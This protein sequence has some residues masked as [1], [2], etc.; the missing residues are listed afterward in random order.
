MMVAL[1]VLVDVQ[2]TR[3]QAT[4]VNEVAYFRFDVPP[5]P[6][7]FVFRSDDP[8]VIQEA[9]DVLN[10]NRSSRMVIGTIVKQPR[11]YNAPWS[12]HLDP[13]SVR[14]ADNAVE[15]CDA[16]IQFVEDHLAEICGATLPDCEW[17]PWSSR[18]IAEVAADTTPTPTPIPTATPTVVVPPTRTP[19]LTPTPS[20]EPEY[21]HY[22]PFV[23]RG[24]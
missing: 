10:G 16:T 20:P 4:F 14:F 5:A 2:A 19:I 3:T 8:A 15:V 7:T 18:V 9:R 24:K 1:V 22:L 13:V 12:Y 11:D 6:E 21:L 17:C 23:A